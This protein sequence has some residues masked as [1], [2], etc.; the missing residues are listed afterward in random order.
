M[1][2]GQDKDAR[3]NAIV[4]ARQRLLDS[5]PA[6][7]ET[8]ELA[9]K[10]TWM[11]EFKGCV[12]LLAKPDCIP[13]ELFEKFRKVVTRH[14][15]NSS[16]AAQWLFQ[17]D[18][19]R[20]V[21]DTFCHGFPHLADWIRVEYKIYN[22][23]VA[24]RRRYAHQRNLRPYWQRQMPLE[25]MLAADAEEE[26]EI[27]AAVEEARRS[28]NEEEK[29]AAAQAAAEETDADESDED[30]EDSILVA[31]ENENRE[32]KKAAVVD[33][34]ETETDESDTEEDEKTDTKEGME[35]DTD[36][37]AAVEEEKKK[38]P[39]AV[40]EKKEEIV[41]EEE[42]EEV[43]I[44]HKRKRDVESDEENQKNNSALAERKQADET[45]TAP[46]LPTAEELAANLASIIMPAVETNVEVSAAVKEKKP[47]AEGDELD[48][49][50]VD[51]TTTPLP[52]PRCD[53]WVSDKK[54]R[55]EEKASMDAKRN[56]LDVDVVMLFT[57][58]QRTCLTDE[59]LTTLRDVWVEDIAA[60]LRNHLYKVRGYA[61][62]ATTL[63]LAALMEER[64]HRAKPMSS[65]AAALWLVLN[66]HRLG[67]FKAPTHTL[68]FNDIPITSD[69]LYYWY[70]TVD[71]ITDVHYH[72]FAADHSKDVRLVP[73]KKSK[74]FEDANTDGD[75]TEP[76]EYYDPEALKTL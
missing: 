59:V 10:L 11:D 21:K 62:S 74:L 57:L 52:K 69:Y 40:E 27:A 66:K 39:D 55:S 4:D 44:H 49:K 65:Y 29:K 24:Y 26:K 35:D 47:E 28:E 16:Q 75:E 63:M 18:A 54:Q 71:Y 56:L 2:N 60:P 3:H 41:A 33:P 25:D 14:N 17:K 32:E 61:G 42:E 8:T 67:H 36:L 53:K 51:L 43:V 45:T 58:D 1:G 50:H 13:V 30:A 76:E 22:R 73:F 6:M 68:A 34:D 48:Q 12:D 23:A 5:G 72:A 15:F 9:L 38:E 31:A 70:A 20:T 46:F 7:H 37:S 64:L 19:T